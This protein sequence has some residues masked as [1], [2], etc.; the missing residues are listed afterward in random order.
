MV[1]VLFKALLKGFCLA[2][3]QLLFVL[4]RSNSSLFQFWQVPVTC[5]SQASSIL[6][7]GSWQPLWKMIH[8]IQTRSVSPEEDLVIPISAQHRRIVGYQ[9]QLTVMC[10]E[11]E[12]ARQS[13]YLMQIGNE[14]AKLG[15]SLSW[16]QLCKL[17]ARGLLWS[18]ILHQ[19]F[20]L[21]ALFRKYILC[22][23]LIFDHA[24]PK[25]ALT[26]WW[27]AALRQSKAACKLWMSIRLH[28]NA[29][30]ACDECKRGTPPV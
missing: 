24:F 1:H 15:Y 27:W 18:H 9:T 4:G 3:H 20:S 8:C 25:C 7:E 6:L 19:A 5:M 17:L 2:R 30:A 23:S 26:Y 16:R 29:A 21:W 22:L 12:N 10:S 13:E 11:L 28:V 14:I